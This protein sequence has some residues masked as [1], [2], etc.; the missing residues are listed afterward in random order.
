MKKLQS[1]FL[2]VVMLTV[3]LC[4]ANIASAQTYN[5][6]MTF[7]VNFAKWNGDADKFA[8]DLNQ[9]MALE[10]FK[11]YN[12][13][14]KPRTG[15]CFGI[16]YEFLVTKRFIIRPE[17]NY[18]YKG[19]KFKHDGTI[20]FTYHYDTYTLDV[21]HDMIM[22]TNYIELPLLFRVNLND[23]DKRTVP[24]FFAGPSVSYLV[25]SKMKSKITVDG[26]TDK[27]SEKFDEFEK[28]DAGLYGGFGVAF[29]KSI[30][31]ELRYNY[32]FLPIVDEDLNDGYKMKNSMFSIMM[33]I[34]FMGD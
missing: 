34:G 27:D 33:N 30:L 17:L 3:A 12:F 26:E 25:V 31:L 23:D 21:K 2:L 16:F 11:G 1:F 10:G 14:V 20:T 24:Y 15:I 8:D 13:E 4:I 6:G 32:N 9:G 18:T 7:G 5:G 22:Q 19:T 29:S 28:F